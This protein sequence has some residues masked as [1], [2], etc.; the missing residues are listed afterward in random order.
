M[1]IHSSQWS[2]CQA[3]VN[4]AQRGRPI[5]GT[6]FY[7][8]YLDDCYI[9]W[10]AQNSFPCYW[11][12][13]LTVKVNVFNDRG[14]P[15]IFTNVCQKSW[16]IKNCELRKNS[17]L[18]ASLKFST[19]ILFEIQTEQPQRRF[20]VKGCTAVKMYSLGFRRSHDKCLLPFEHSWFKSPAF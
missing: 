15:L 14:H 11:N 19:G 2:S 8:S 20:D 13:S 4:K 5:E 16:R 1:N 6:F 18:R 12:L 17:S 9:L 10:V 7:N 3:R